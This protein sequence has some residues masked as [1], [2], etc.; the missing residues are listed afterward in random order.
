MSRKE[1]LISEAVGKKIRGVIDDSERALII[2][3]GGE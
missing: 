2:Y 1:V 3:E